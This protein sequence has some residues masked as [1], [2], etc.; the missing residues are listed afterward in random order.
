[1]LNN[2]VNTTK[3]ITPPLQISILTLTL[4]VTL[5]TDWA[6]TQA[7][8]LGEGRGWNSES[9]GAVF[10]SKGGVWTCSLSLPCEDK[11]KKQPPGNR[12]SSPEPNHANTL[13]SAL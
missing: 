5:L 12:G 1:M 13:T 4:R 7:L 8:E 10:L 6:L 9:T 2:L 11:G 3:S